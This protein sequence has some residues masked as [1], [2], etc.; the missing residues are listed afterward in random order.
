MRI[1]VIGSGISGF[2][3][4]MALQG[5]PGVDVVLYEREA[6]A[7]GHAHTVDVDYD[8]LP[9]AVDA[10]FIVYNELNYPNLTA[11]FAW[12]GIETIESDMSFALSSDDG[13]FEWCGRHVAPLGGLFAQAGNAFDPGFYR[14][15]LG[16][17][18]LQKRA[19]ADHAA[20]RIGGETLA[21]YLQSIRCPARV[22]DD[23]IVPMG[24]AIW[25]MT[26]GETLGFP[27]RSFFAFFNNHKL[28]QWDRP[29]WRT[30]RGGSRSYVAKLTDRLG[31]SV[32][33][34]LAATSVRRENG[35]VV[36]SALK[37]EDASYDAVVFATHAPTALSLLADADERQ[38][39]VI[40]AFRVSHNK[41]VVHRD[42]ALMPVRRRAWASWNALR[43]S[44]SERAAVTYWMNRLQAIPETH[45]LFVTLNPDRP[46]RDDRVFATF[47]FE[48]PLYD[49]AA[50]A[51]QERLEA[52]QGRG[53]VFFAGAWTG[54]GF[55]EDGLRSGL[56]AA[57]RLGG[58]APWLR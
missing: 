44:G 45:P 1:A 22:R 56:A 14:F 34:G 5:R 50:I 20:G 39:A 18:A 10:G 48:H 21:A 49:A 47:A 40:G 13:A 3:A 9:I 33:S 52:I 42:A 58:V 27:A 24:A 46:V 28:L 2:G 31:A 17:R 23:Y 12:A 25:S 41:V 29:K 57:A 30:V 36:V 51:A 38:R 53:N 8:G 11:L 15:L 6:R 35:A 7:G 55:H 19:I 26:P 16:I 4:A 32:R 43:R 37:G 54:Y